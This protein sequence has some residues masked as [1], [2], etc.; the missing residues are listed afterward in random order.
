MSH[1]YVNHYLRQNQP[2]GR[3]G[4]VADQNIQNNVVLLENLLNKE[5]SQKQYKKG[6]T[7][8]F[9]DIDR[10]HNQALTFEEKQAF[11]WFK[12]SQ[13]IPMTG[14]EEYFLK[15]EKKD[16]TSAKATSS[17][18]TTQETV[19]KDNHF[20]DIET[21]AK[22]VI[23]GKTT[24]FQNVY[25]K[26]VYNVFTTPEGYKRY[27]NLSHVEKIGAEKAAE[28]DE[29]NKQVKDL[30]RKGALFFSNGM[31]LPYCYF[32][33]GNMYDRQLA[34]EKDEAFIVENFGQA[35][36]DNHAE[37]IKK[38]KPNFLSVQVADPRDR[39]II[40][41]ISPL[42]KN[43]EMY[44]LGELRD[45]TGFD[46]TEIIKGSVSNWK[47]FSNLSL[48]ERNEMVSRW[49]YN[50]INGNIKFK[51]SLCEAFKF[52]LFEQDKNNF[53]TVSASRIERYYLDKRP[54][55]NKISDEEQDT[56]NKYAPQI[57][58]ELF[59]KFLNDALT[60]EDQQKLDF[61]FNRQYNG[62]ADIA[63]HKVPIG[64][65][66]SAYFKNGTFAFTEAQK[67]AIAFME[68]A[69]AGILAYD[70]GV[71]KTISAIITAA[72]NIKQGKC[73]RPIVIVPNGTYKKWK[74][75]MFGGVDE[76][77][78]QK[79]YGVLSGTDITL[80]EFYNLGVDTIKEVKGR[81]KAGG[82]FLDEPLPEKSITLMTY[83]G[84]RA[85]GIT[86]FEKTVA[87]QE[88]FDILEQADRVIKSA[89]DEAKR[90]AAMISTVSIVN[91][92][93]KV[94]FTKLKGDM[95]IL[96]EAHSAK[97]IFSGVKADN[98]GNKRYELTSSTSAMGIK[99]FFFCN[100]IIRN[101]GGNVLLLTATPFSNSPVEIYSMLSLVGYA[102]IKDMGLANLNTFMCTFVKQSLEYVNK[103]DGSIDL[104]YTVK[105]FNNRTILQ[106]ILNSHILYKTGE[107][108]GVKRPVKINLPKLK[109]TNS[110]GRV[111]SLKKSEQV[112]T[113]L[114]PNI[115]QAKKQ[116]EIESDL[117]EFMGAIGNKGSGVTLGDI[118]RCLNQNLANALSPYFF[119]KELPNPVDFVE[120]SPKVE[121]V[122]NCIKSVKD[123]HEE[124]KQYCSGQVIYC[125]RGKQFFPLMQ[126]YLNSEVGF[127]KSVKVPKD[128]PYYN[129]RLNEVEIIDSDTSSDD[130]ELIKEAFLAGVVKVIIG[131]S[132]IREGIDLQRRGTCLYALTVD[133]NPTDFK[134]L[135]GRIWRQGN[136]FG[137][138]RIVMPLL[139]DSMDVFVFQKLEEKTARINDIWYKAGRG[140]VID[141]EALDPEEIKLALF[142]KV[143]LLIKLR[144][145]LL[146][147]ELNRKALLNRISYEAL[148]TYQARYESYVATRK[149][150]LVKINAIKITI[151]NSVQAN[152]KNFLEI[153]ARQ[154]NGY[155]F[156]DEYVNKVKR[157]IKDGLEL[158]EDID[159][160]ERATEQDDRELLRICR[161]AET[162]FVLI[163][164]NESS[165]HW[166]V[167]E[168]KTLISFVRKTEKDMLTP[169]G[170]A[171]EDAPRLMLELKEEYAM[172]VTRNN[173]LKTRE[174]ELEVEKEIIEQK[175]KYAVE[176]KSPIQRAEEFASLNYYLA[177]G[178]DQKVGTLL[179]ESTP[180]PQSDDAQRTRRLRLLK[181]RT[182]TFA[183]AQ[184]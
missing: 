182:Q 51:L 49:K 66:C 139:Q 135:E 94:D 156:S 121:Y 161:R 11:V 179:P 7:M 8:S 75:D 97:N 153:K 85:M 6:D 30:V 143:E 5:K 26:I 76:E 101:Y 92:G 117:R 13:G 41:A 89:R 118:G 19:I 130:R 60:F 45:D 48:K 158:Q 163:E 37:I 100:Y 178:Q 146:F 90:M 109:T 157:K 57:C 134:Q 55:T 145:D 24:K 38:S 175:Q 105:A 36:F 44:S 129:Q 78:G 114:S 21:I 127:L 63:Y 3:L 137:Y 164:R 14:W 81:F 87:Y 31:Y 12:R 70:V 176:G 16:Y 107:D 88:M 23:I 140:N 106:K 10:E 160:F 42:S 39:P 132:S 171:A 151:V 110:D 159:A 120:N 71:G 67:E 166:K 28:A 20:R 65:E 52:W 96:D 126:R 77:T 62:Y 53:V 181:L 112:L 74:T 69:S 144:M 136:T 83:E 138:V 46:L 183:F 116:E 122:M 155:A 168:F 131:T 40:L 4:K 169:R 2:L 99:A 18:K 128:S 9:E 162:Y 124:R 177:F 149:D 119:E 15:A 59:A 79:I 86:G 17:F 165:F 1:R 91:K 154:A 167:E 27:V 64:F 103:A 82:V 73:K 72:N 25:G 125:N 32:S 174:G 133:W 148:E 95:F 93:A 150:I 141:Q 47:C 54:L 58:E 43:K 50:D 113:Y 152:E 115:I 173:Y 29:Q 98:E 111:V 33:F 56:I 22:G 108:A 84:F 172:L 123:W 35:I 147:K 184:K 170:F 34:L 104:G 68:V 142:T 102:T 61:V 80:N 180:Q